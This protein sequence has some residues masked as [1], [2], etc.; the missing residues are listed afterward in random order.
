M[1]VI[2]VNLSNQKSVLLLDDSVVL[3]TNNPYNGLIACNAVDREK[4]I[5]NETSAPEKVR[6]ILV[7][8]GVKLEGEYSVNT[9]LNNS[10]NET[11][12]PKPKEEVVDFDSVLSKI[13]FPGFEQRQSEMLRNIKGQIKPKRH[14]ATGEELIIIPN[15]LIDLEGET[16]QLRTIIGG[17]ATVGDVII[18]VHNTEY[19]MFSP[20]DLLNY[21]KTI[22]TSYNIEEH[23]S[24]YYGE[25]DTDVVEGVLTDNYLLTANEDGTFN[26]ALTFKQD[27]IAEKTM[28][29]A[30]IEDMLKYITDNTENEIEV[31]FTVKE[32]PATLFNWDY[33]ADRQIGEVDVEAKAFVAS[34]LLN[35]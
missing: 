33:Y 34:D 16:T 9:L 11:S 6:E 20:L 21:N 3:V 2:V 13:N 14:T 8:G 7:K 26:L 35:R 27:I 28:S 12:A 24:K 1:K 29:Y 31:F 15:T 23:F 25:L 22:D 30:E 19:G 10:F 32:V 5:Y 4:V 17:T 18:R